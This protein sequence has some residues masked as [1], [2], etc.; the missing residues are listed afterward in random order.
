MDALALQLKTHTRDTRDWGPV[1]AYKVDGVL[2]GTG[3][4]KKQASLHVSYR[5]GLA[6]MPKARCIELRPPA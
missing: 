5:K 4:S 1:G 3:R 2:G 6:H